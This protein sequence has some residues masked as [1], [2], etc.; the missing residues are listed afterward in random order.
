MKIDAVRAD[1]NALLVL[2]NIRVQGYENGN[3]CQGFD[4]NETMKILTVNSGS[5][6]FS[7]ITHTQ[8]TNKMFH[9]IQQILADMHALPIALRLLKPKKFEKTFRPHFKP[10]DMTYIDPKILPQVY[11]RLEY[12]TMY[13][14]L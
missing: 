1:R 8:T 12:C 5:I 2:Q 3:R 11:K 6:T 14:Q 10:I 9:F 13:K 7:R 4:K